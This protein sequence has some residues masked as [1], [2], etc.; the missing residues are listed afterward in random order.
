M[1]VSTWSNSVFIAVAIDY[2][3][4]RPT[5]KAVLTLTRP[6]FVP[7]AVKKLDK[8][9]LSGKSLKAEPDSTARMSTRTRGAKG[10]LEAAQ[11]GIIHGNGTVT[12]I[13]GGGRAVVLYGLPG[14]LP[15]GVLADNLRNFKLA[16]VEQG[17]PVVVKIEK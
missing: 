10:A 12:S 5:G 17:R 13:S 7:A 8:A 6:E 9:F 2:R 14:K 1:F 11:R 16:G 15:A 3:R 4:F